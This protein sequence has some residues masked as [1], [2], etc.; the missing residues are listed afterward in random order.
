MQEQQAQKVFGKAIELHHAGAFSKAETLYKQVLRH[1]PNLVPV[2]TNLGA[3]LMSQGKYAAALKPLEQA[4]ALNPTYMDAYGNRA[5]TLLNQGKLDLALADYQ[6]LTQM[7]PKN[8]ASHYN[9]ANVLMQAG[10][11]LEAKAAF[12][13]ALSFSPEMYQAHYNLGIV[14]VQLEEREAGRDSFRQALALKPGS[15]AA[16]VNLG[17][18][19]MDF[20]NLAEAKA[21]FSLA[22][23]VDPAFNLGFLA[24]AKLFMELGE[25]DLAL[26]D[27]EHAYALNDSDSATLI[28]RGNALGAHGDDAGAE[29]MYREVLRADPKH[30]AAR[31]NL[32]RLISR[33]VPA[34][35]FTMLADAGRNAAFK[36]AIE[37]AVTPTSVVLD[38]GTGSGLLA[39]MA[40]R[41][42]ARHVYACEVSE[43]L[44]VVAGDIVQDNGYA[45]KITIYAKSSL[46]LAEDNTLP[47]KANLVISEILDA[48]LIGEGV[49]P[50]LRHAAR[51][52]GTAD[53][54]MI[55]A[56]AT[57][58]AQL[59]ALPRLRKVNPLGKI[60]GFDLKAF[61]RFRNRVR[62][63]VVHLEQVLHQ[64][65]SKAVRVEKFDFRNLPPAVSDM[66]PKVLTL[67]FP[68]EKAGEAHAVLI[69]FDLHLDAKLT[70]SSGKGGEMD[71]WGQAVCFLPEDRSFKVGT[72]AQVRLSR[73]DSTWAVVE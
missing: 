35:H 36:A 49:L 64:V 43:P 59:V 60:A 42:G 10:Q 31:R 39:M 3:A 12:L 19:E 67:D 62:N 65:L 66:K 71:H 13:K 4:I 57:V 27:I 55:P 25:V 9:L 50:G 16:A 70:V 1:Y 20:G 5:A 28:M 6:L 40:A 45:E 26:L 14:L 68:I 11:L 63:P 21:A 41:A 56:G 51:E 29:E 22:I 72:V 32:S 69:W 8:A 7:D 17:N 37:R 54:A 34:W 48:A 33:Q 30:V 2:L 15:A 52:L 46:K 53:V 61:D 73:T 23:A 58:W 38:I 44:A 47:E 18:V 24:R